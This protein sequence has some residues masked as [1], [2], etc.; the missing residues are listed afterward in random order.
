[1]FIRFLAMAVLASGTAGTMQAEGAAG[2][3]QATPP[4][5]YRVY[6]NPS[7][8]VHVRPQ[9]CGGKS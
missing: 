8:S 2:A 1:M 3:G 9:P 6:R 7:N 4:T 5:K